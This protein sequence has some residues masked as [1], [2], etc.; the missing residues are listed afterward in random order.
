MSL[1]LFLFF[2]HKNYS[3]KTTEQLNNEQSVK[4]KVQTICVLICV[5]TCKEV[6]V[7]TE[8]RFSTNC[9]N[10]VKNNLKCEMRNAVNSSLKFIKAH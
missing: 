3:A 8:T 7:W 5:R 1:Q 4:N 6:W 10:D 9:Y 2:V